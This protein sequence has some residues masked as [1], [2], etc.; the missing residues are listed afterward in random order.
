M[1]FNNGKE[2]SRIHNLFEVQTNHEADDNAEEIFSFRENE[3]L[4]V[5]NDVANFQSMKQLEDSL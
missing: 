2:D 4:N 5:E 1:T 3:H